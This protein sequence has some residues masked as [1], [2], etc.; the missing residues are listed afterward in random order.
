NEGRAKLVGVAVTVPGVEPDVAVIAVTTVDINVVARIQGKI[1]ARQLR[2]AGDTQLVDIEHGVN[3]AG[4]VIGDMNWIGVGDT[5]IVAVVALDLKREV[6][7]SSPRVERS[8]K[9]SGGKTGPGNPIE[10][11]RVVLQSA[12][13][14]VIVRVRAISGRNGKRAEICRIGRQVII[15]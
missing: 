8:G 13:R 3:D 9:A 5:R 1:W 4:L 7:M 15:H 14:G 11:F 6:M 12:E 10:V 2:H